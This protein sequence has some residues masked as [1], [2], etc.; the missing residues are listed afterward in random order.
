[1]LSSREAYRLL[2]VGGTAIKCA[3]GRSFP[4]RSGGTREQ[5]AQALRLAVGDPAALRGL[6][7]AIPGPFDYREGVFRMNHKFAAVKGMP[8][9]VVACIPEGVPVRFMHDVHAVLAGAVRMMGLGGNTAVVTLGTGLGFGFTVRG[10]IQANALGSPARSLYNLPCRDGILEDYVSARGIRN[11]YARETGDCQV[12]AQDIAQRARVGDRFA[13][14]AFRTAGTIL[15]E[16]LPPLLREL[17]TGTL[18][19]GGQVS[20]SFDLVEAPLRE[21]LAGVPGL[22]TVGTVPEGAVFEGLASLFEND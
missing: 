7:V 22:K 2:D 21:A 16:Y 19:F 20:R 5:I 11:L 15:G 12:S 8:F 18:L 6:G 9:R 3:D 10:E 1:M 13:R 14:D 4:S 17:E